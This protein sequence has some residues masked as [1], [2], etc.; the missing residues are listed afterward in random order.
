MPIKSNFSF[1]LSSDCKDQVAKNHRFEWDS[2]EKVINEVIKAENEVFLDVQPKYSFICLRV[3]LEKIFEKVNNQ[4]ELRLFDSIKALTESWPSCWALSG[5]HQIR[6]AGNE[7]AHST[8][9]NKTHQNLIILLDKFHDVLRWYLEDFLNVFNVGEVPEFSPN[10]YTIQEPEQEFGPKISGR[11]NHQYTSSELDNLVS[12]EDAY[13]P[14]ETASKG[15]S[16]NEKQKKL[17]VIDTGKHFVNAPPGTGKT[18]L[19]VERLFNASNKFQPEDIVCLTF[20]NRAA[21]EMEDRITRSI[22]DVDFFIGNIHAFCMNFLRSQATIDE[23]RKFRNLSLLDEKFKAIIENDVFVSN[24]NPNVLNNSKFS[25]REV[26]AI[27]KLLGSDNGLSSLET[28]FNAIDSKTAIA[29]CL[30]REAGSINA[31]KNLANEQWER[32]KKDLNQSSLAIDLKKNYSFSDSDITGLVEVYLDLLKSRKELTRSYDFDDLIAYGLI[33]VAKS[34]RKYLSI[35]VDECQDLNVFQWALVELLTTDNSNVMAFGDMAQSIYSFMGASSELLSEYTNT[36]EQHNLDM[37]YRSNNK[38]VELLN[39]YRKVNLPKDNLPSFPSKESPLEPSTLLVSYPNEDDEAVGVTNAIRKI[40]STK[41]SQGL[42]RNVGLLLRNNKD[43]DLYATH[44]NENHIKTFRLSK[45]DIMK[46]PSVVDFM[47]LLRVYSGRS[48]R[49]DW[50]KLFYRLAKGGDQKITRLNAL[51]VI[52]S[53]FLLGVSPLSCLS[54]TNE[55]LADYAAKKFVTSYDSGR[56]VVFDTETTSTDVTEAELLQ[57]AAVAIQD[58]VI[59]EKFNQYIRIDPA[60]ES[61]EKFAQDLKASSEIHHIDI[62]KLKDQGRES[63][64]VFS[65]FLEFLGGD[66]T[67]LVAHNAPYDIAVLERNFDKYGDKQQNHLEKFL[68]KVKGRVFDTLSISRVLYPTLKSY[69]LE[70]MLNEF[71]LQGVNSHDA[72]D[73]VIATSSLV[74]KIHSDLSDKIPQI[75]NILSENYMAFLKFNNSMNELIDMFTSQSTNFSDSRSKNNQL[76]VSDLLSQWNEYALFKETWYE[77]VNFAKLIG[78]IEIKLIPWIER[79]L[80]KGSLS[81]LVSSNDV[82][83]LSVMSESD[84]IDLDFDKVVV[85]TIHRAKGLQFETTIVPRA[86]DDVYPSYFSVKNQDQKGMEEDA[87]LLYV[88]LSRPTDKLI[89]TYYKTYRGYTKAVSRFIENIKNYF[90]YVRPDT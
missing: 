40:I 14:E 65:E 58:G 8:T 49:I 34:E 89:V 33:N 83:R 28:L 63:H 47:S 81:E 11:K 74:T 7:I 77:K 78:D 50:Y 86:V 85:S 79:H 24:F 64:Q 5:M 87:R 61:N 13:A 9:T 67:V 3:A 46:H 44:L 21:K 1:F 20:T 75:D 37:N 32:S 84:L 70:S 10:I 4:P 31:L 25:K 59:V 42:D 73:D 2:F 17:S 41:N 29:H 66:E 55:L 76:R 43:V 57:L 23:Q 88:A 22:G 36:F 35:Q 54:P 38:I 60:L 45:N 71:K 68:Q 53:L 82:E 62:R 15:A 48:N 12:D 18:H 51:K 26:V 56:I 69:K 52:D 30:Y 39:Q 16:L 19:L 27:Q 80:S 72:L 6:V 90:D